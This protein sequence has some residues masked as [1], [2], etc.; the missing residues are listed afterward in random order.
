MEHSPRLCPFYLSSFLF[1]SQLLRLGNCQWSRENQRK[2]RPPKKE[3]R[4]RTKDMFQTVENNQNKVRNKEQTK[5]ENQKFDL[6]TKKQLWNSSRFCAQ[7]FHLHSWSAGASLL[8]VSITL[9]LLSFITVVPEFGATS[10]KWEIL[11]QWR[12]TR[13]KAPGC[14]VSATHIF[15]SLSFLETQRGVAIICVCWEREGGWN[16]NWKKGN[17]QQV[18]CPAITSPDDL[19][20]PFYLT[21]HM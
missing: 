20:I 21:L 4:K 8:L 13:K 5:K 16:R 7:P 18:W 17:F 1:I 15:V 10:F 3:R 19:N 12:E 9:L 14:L 2:Q 11:R 6:K